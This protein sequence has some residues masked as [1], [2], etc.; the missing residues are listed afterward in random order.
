MLL[1]E[2]DYNSYRTSVYILIKSSEVI[3]F[4]IVDAIKYIEQC[5]IET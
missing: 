1:N 5:F 4:N 3:L 2:I